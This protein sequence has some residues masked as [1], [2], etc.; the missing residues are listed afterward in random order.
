MTSRILLTGASG[1]VGGRLLPALEG[2]GYACAAW[3]GGRRCWPAGDVQRQ[4]SSPA[5]SSIGRASMPRSGASTPR[6][7][8]STRWDPAGSFEDADRQAARNFAE[9]AKAAGVSRIVYSEAWATTTT[10][11]RRTCA[12][13]RRSESAARIWRAGA[14][15]SGVD[16]HRLGQ[17]LVRDDPL[18][19]GTA[20]NHDYTPLGQ[21]A[22][23]A[24]RRST[25]C[26][27][28]WW[29]PCQLPA[30]KYRVYEIGGADQVTYAD[31]MRVYAKRQFRSG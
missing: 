11:S 20:A 7:T 26:W 23:A 27:R 31:V 28:S 25:T 6:I 2:R 22:S 30:S 3:R 9:A 21:R 15:I 10:R 4:R 14:R 18:A 29:Q 8:W 1:Y 12:A 5:T 16:R 19:R 17:S 24:N 13:V